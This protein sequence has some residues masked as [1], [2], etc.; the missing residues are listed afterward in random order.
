MRRKIFDKDDYDGEDEVY[1]F[2]N[3]TYCDLD[4]IYEEKIYVNVMKNHSDH[5]LL[6]GWRKACYDFFEN[7]IIHKRDTGAYIKYYSR[8][9]IILHKLIEESEKE[10]RKLYSLKIK[11]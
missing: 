3:R 2:L 4:I 10:F 9:R 7:G 1:E 5:E 6:Y 8:S 11:G